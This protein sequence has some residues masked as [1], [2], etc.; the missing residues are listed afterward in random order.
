M[1]STHPSV[2]ESLQYTDTSEMRVLLSIL[3]YDDESVVRVRDID[4][5]HAYDWHVIDRNVA[6]SSF[7]IGRSARFL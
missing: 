7:F 4:D 6:T 2:R 3:L 1:S 5:D